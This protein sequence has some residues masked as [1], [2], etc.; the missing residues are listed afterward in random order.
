M[1]PGNDLGRAG[2]R[3][4]AGC[5]FASGEVA[6]A[7]P[8]GGFRPRRDS[9]ARAQRGNRTHGNDLGRKWLELRVIGSS[10]PKGRQMQLP[11]VQ[12]DLVLLLL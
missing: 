7:V 8:P 11:Q 2:L 5:V 1:K 6:A 12:R 10:S 3:L 9:F 4:S